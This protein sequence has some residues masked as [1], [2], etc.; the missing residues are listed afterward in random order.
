MRNLSSGRSG[1]VEMTDP[2]RS[3]GAPEYGR[4]LVQVAESTYAWLQ[5]NGSWNESNA[6]LVVGEGASLLIDTLIDPPHTR[7]MLDAMKPFTD[8]APIDILVNTHGDIDH[9]FG[10][11]LVAPAVVVATE[12]TARAIAHEKPEHSRGRQRILSAAHRLSELGLL[13]GKL[14]PRIQYIK[15]M[16]APYD[17]RAVRSYPPTRMFRGQLTLKIGGRDVTLLDVGPAHTL[18]D[19]IVLA[20]N[21]SVAFTGDILFVGVTPVM[22]AGPVAGWIGALDRLLSLDCD[23]F[24]PGHGPVCGKAEVEALRAY[25]VYLE[26]AARRGLAS[27]K[28]AVRVARDIA[29]SD[30]FQHTP[31]AAWENPE[32][33]V[34]NVYTMAKPNGRSLRPPG[35]LELPWMMLHVAALAD[36]LRRRRGST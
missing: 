28:S 31:F 24:V 12:Q 26:A 15:G 13:A 5:P 1:Q 36:E 11:H 16:L 7:R 6:G 33:I 23:T 19:L 2:S 4:G 17:F 25:W 8:P 35:T 29:L 32:R 34:I 27:G 14:K 20:P 22:W 10:N 30:E 9:I 3:Q 21:A 18:S